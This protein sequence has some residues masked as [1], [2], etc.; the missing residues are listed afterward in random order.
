MR[1]FGKVFDVIENDRVVFHGDYKEI[2]SRYGFSINHFHMQANNG[3]KLKHKYRIKEVG[4]KRKYYTIKSKAREVK[5]IKIEDICDLLYCDNNYIYG[6][7][8]KNKPLIGEWTIEKIEYQEEL[9]D[10]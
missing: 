7:I 4:V 9:Y 10:C 2:C 8:R 6:Q 5:R 1:D 3:A